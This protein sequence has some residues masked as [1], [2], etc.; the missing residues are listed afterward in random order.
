M[1]RR[2]TVELQMLKG[3]ADNSGRHFAKTSLRNDNSTSTKLASGLWACA[4]G[5]DDV[6]LYHL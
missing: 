6:L 2:G 5:H 1:P 4:R 3:K